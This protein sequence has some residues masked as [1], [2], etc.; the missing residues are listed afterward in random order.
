MN[1]V[2]GGAG[3]TNLLY[4]LEDRPPAGRTVLYAAQW[5]FFT[6]ANSAV[7]PVV[8]GNALG[9]DQAGVAGLVQRTF[10]FQG[11]A[12]FLQVGLGHRLPII[13]GP[14]GMWWGI[15]ITLAAI[16]PGL[17][18]PLSVLRTDLEL[19][20]MAA[21]TIV[22]LTG[23]SGLV[24]KARQ[25]FTP[26]VTGSVLVLLGIQLSGTFVRGM[27][28]LGAGSGVVDWRAC[29]VSLSVVTVVVLVNLK[30][31]GFIK[32]LA[33][34]AGIAAGWLAAFPAGLAGG[35]EWGAGSFISTPEIFAWG[36]PTF[37]GGVVLACVLTGLLVLSNLVAS[38][39]AMEKALGVELPA[40]TYNRGVALTG[41][42][43]ILA[44]TGATVGF[45]PYS[46][47]AAMVSMT[48]VASRLPFALFALALAVLGLLPPVAAFLASIPE[49][50]G[51]SVLL[52]SFCQMVV[53][54]L[55]DYARLALNERDSF[56]IGITLLFGT[57]AMFLPPGVLAGLPSLVRYIL[58]NG[59]LCGML[60]CLL[61]E[62]VFLPEKLFARKN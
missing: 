62:H 10:F 18:K 3:L 4:G 42:A 29:L 36:P 32:S 28:G 27:L 49:P 15:F 1:G 26:P 7:V 11:V 43:D 53:F 5:L 54:G 6:L 14:S 45:V 34:L 55:R 21:G 19:G 51:Y 9:L 59:F 58:G 57:G 41:L 13:E 47:G 40:I 30:A 39:M 23:V 48:G 22:L 20:V 38:I 25:L 33:V 60:L 8:V 12:S 16:A 44:G 46:A 31:R 35:L 56:V 2:S 37:D 52:A 24:G 61:L 17:G 50:A